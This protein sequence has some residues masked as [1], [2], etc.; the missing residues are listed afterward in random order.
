MTASGTER[1]PSPGFF[2][3][4]VPSF[5]LTHCAL[6]ALPSHRRVLCQVPACW[7]REGLKCDF[8]RP[9]IWLRHPGDTAVRVDQ[10]SSQLHLPGPRNG[11][12]GHRSRSRPTSPCGRNC[13]A[14]TNIAQLCVLHTLPP[15]LK[16]KGMRGFGVPGHATHEENSTRTCPL[17]TFV[18]QC[19]D[20]FP[21]PSSLRTA[22]HYGEPALNVG[23][24]SLRVRD[25]GEQDNTASYATRQ[26][27]QTEPTG[28]TLTV[29][30]Y[31]S[32]AVCLTRERRR[33]VV[34]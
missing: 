19:L 26:D 18:S 34:V 22:D 3:Q 13:C 31:W 2:H 24:Y 33:S 7:W 9:H 28:H 6:A 16:K 17:C 30:L 11:L 8:A 15:S 21:D 1:Y 10:Q 29:D 12:V 32:L 25:P 27:E 14:L 4:G 20:S 5:A 23:G